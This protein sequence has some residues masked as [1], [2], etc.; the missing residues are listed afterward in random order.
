[1]DSG[2]PAQIPP[3]FFKFDGRWADGNV[4]TSIGGAGRC[5]TRLVWR[6]DVIG[7]DLIAETA[8]AGSSPCDGVAISAGSKRGTRVGP[9]WRRYQPF[10]VRRYRFSVL[11][12]DE[13][14]LPPRL[15]RRPILT[16]AWGNTLV[17]VH[18]CCF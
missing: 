7:R 5:D 12:K 9:V 1:M 3:N 17:V 8:L 14:E 13:E 15:G 11:V 16:V 10:S 2:I 4:D 6:R 18:R